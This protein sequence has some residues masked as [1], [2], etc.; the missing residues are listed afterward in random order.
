MKSL[1]EIIGQLIIILAIGTIFSFIIWK[2][3][4]RKTDFGEFLNKYGELL[5][6]AGLLV[7][8]VIVAIFQWLT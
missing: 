5:A 2:F 8:V 7:I 1:E 6:Y 3:K 4:K